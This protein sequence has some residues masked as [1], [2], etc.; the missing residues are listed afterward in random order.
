MEKLPQ[1]NESFGELQWGPETSEH[2]PDSKIFSF[3]R[4]GENV[5]F[6]L[7]TSSTGELEGNEFTLEEK[8]EG[9]WKNSKSLPGL[10]RFPERFRVAWTQ[11]I[12]QPELAEL[13]TLLTSRGL[14]V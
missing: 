2:F 7:R 4:N 10:D 6:A 14:D 1:K 13:H 8:A 9:G 5:F 12:H 11:Q 3:I